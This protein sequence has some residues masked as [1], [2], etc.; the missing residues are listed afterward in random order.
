M[1]QTVVPNPARGI[2]HPTEA[3]G[4]DAGIRPSRRVVLG[5][6]A[7][8]PLG[9][10][11]L[12]GWHAGSADARPVVSGHHPTRL[13]N[14]AH[15]NDLLA[16]IRLHPVA[17]HST[18]RITQQPE[19]RALWVYANRNDDGSY[20]PVGGGNHDTTSNT[21]GQG[22]FDVDD[23]ARAVV[24][25]LRHH[26]LFADRFSRDTAR[27]LL[28]CMCY[29]Q[30]LTGPH[31]GNFLLWM[32]PDGT[33]NPTPTPPDN[34]NPADS[35]TS[36]WTARSIWALGE[37]YAAFR[38]AD[39]EFARFLA[40][41]MELAL[42]ALQRDVL[43]PKY[44][45]HHV[46]HGVRVPAWL[47]TDGADATGEACLGLA[48]YVAASRSPRGRRVLAQLAEGI[49]EF[50]EGT[51]TRYPFRALMPWA[52][53][54]EQ[55]HAWGSEMA[56]GLAAAA[57]VLGRPHLLDAAVGDTAGF[58]AQLLTS[59][60]PD[61]GIQP[62]PTD[63]VQIAY[64][65][66][67]RVRACH[68]TG[69]ACHSAGIRALAGIAAGWFFGANTSG[70]PIYDPATGVTFDG[71]EADGRL[72]RNSGAESTIHGLLTMLVLD[73]NP[74]LARLARAAA[75]IERRDGLTMVEAESAS[76]TGPAVA[77]AP[78]QAWT[79]ESLWSNQ[80]VVAQPG[81]VLAWQLDPADQQRL[82]LPVVELVPGSRARMRF[83]W[84]SPASGGVL[85]TIDLGAVPA[86]GDAASPTRLTPV[87]LARQ[88]PAGATRLQ[89]RT[90][91]ATAA[92]DALLVL[93]LV[94]SLVASG[95][96]GRVA[97]LTSRSGR[98]ERRPMP[99]AG[100]V[101]AFDRSGRR[102]GHAS[103][104]HVDVPAGGFVIITAW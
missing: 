18:H 93:P 102:V 71:V 2:I 62:T 22:S 13:S 35:G 31:S 40:A 52:E 33:L 65:A 98:T 78:A 53:S 101:H 74:D 57:P 11:M 24:V 76:I 79:G 48:P 17:G 61:N 82:V 72:N 50:H 20:T 4:R 91:G 89:A 10:F 19:V 5:A 88:L 56:Q 14:L 100:S 67:A 96:D 41:R 81:S 28:R 37:G 64:G 95:A 7:L 85:G 58:T 39:P 75:H 27:E 25:Y 6:A 87:S 1:A 29:F 46:L 92:C 42:R 103:H 55:W 80:E 99:F 51:T 15:L 69:V 38:H 66:D 47:I 32:Q 83:D 70:Q 30:T 3:T 68:D 43:T 34:P 9:G 104:V 60:G 54:L 73:A 49:A 44:G 59:V 97:L 84:A 45:T 23:I 12:Q 8:A 90:S 36:Y 26:R 77:Q 16:T 63:R 94:A 21:W 86:A